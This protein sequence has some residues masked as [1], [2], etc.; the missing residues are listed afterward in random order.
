L[1]S[2]SYADTSRYFALHWLPLRNRP[3]GAITRADVAGRLQELVKANG[4]IAAARARA[5]LSSLYAWSMRE[6]LCDS[7]PVI[8]TNNPA[9][10]VPSRDRVLADSE[11]AVIWHACADDDFGRIARLLILI[12]ARRREIGGLKWNDVNL[13]TGA[14]LIPGERTKGGRALELILPAAALGILRSTPHRREYVFG[15]RGVGFSSWSTSTASM[16]ARITPPLAPWIL[17]DLRR[18]MRTGLGRL[19][20]QP[21]IAELVIGHTR[22]CVE[23][24]YDRGRYEREKRSALALWADHVLAAVEGRAP[25]VLAFPAV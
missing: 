6:G 13:D 12:G 25:K 3:L 15:D 10:G 21:H 20:V 17:H 8:S 4:R 7:N 22:G 18:S 11:L 2:T 23:A 24:I 5:T 19:G 9:I 16:K 1:R 14:L